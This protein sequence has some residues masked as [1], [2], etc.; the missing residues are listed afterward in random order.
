MRQLKS[1]PVSGHVPIT[2]VPT[3]WD[4]IETRNSKV[5]PPARRPGIILRAHTTP[6]QQA[7]WINF[8]GN[9]DGSCLVHRNSTWTVLLPTI[10][11]QPPVAAI[12]SF[13]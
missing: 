12:D 10:T 8:M 1:V 4:S 13:L 3:V 2:R 11:T 6:N 9:Q 7:V 5:G